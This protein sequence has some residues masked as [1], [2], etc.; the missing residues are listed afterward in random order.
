MAPSLRHGDWV[1]ALRTRRIGPGQVVLARHPERPGFLLVKRAA[2]RQGAG[3]WLESDF[4]DAPGVTDS[5]H[6]GPV[7]PGQ[8]VGRVLVRYWPKPA[9]VFPNKAGPNA[10][11]PVSGADAG[12]GTGTPAVLG[13][14][15]L[16]SLSRAL[17]LGP[18]VLGALL[19]HQGEHLLPGQ[20]D[21]HRPEVDDQAE[22]R[23]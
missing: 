7:A 6:F 18:R 19:G 12:D 5:R 20:L 10:P 3:W 1:I 9:I 13:R 21:R 14:K 8:V 4:G 22:D 17:G 2:R 16:R 23:D 15:R 11:S